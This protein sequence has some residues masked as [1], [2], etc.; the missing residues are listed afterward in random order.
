MNFT[1]VIAIC[2]ATWLGFCGLP[3]YAHAPLVEL[4]DSSREQPIN[5]TWSLD[6]SIAIYGFLANRS[7]VDVVAFELD[8]QKARDGTSLFFHTLVPAC[9]VY[10]DLLPTVAVVGPQQAALPTKSSDDSLPFETGNNDGIRILTNNKQGTTWYEPYSKKNYF[11]QQSA[12]LILNKP[13]RYYLYTWSSKGMT[14]DYVLSIGK[15]E[16]W[17]LREIGR[18]MR[19]MP[20][21]LGDREIHSAACRE[22][23][24]QQP[25]STNPLPEDFH[26]SAQ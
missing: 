8:E 20:R 9:E 15:K 22:E 17:G 5:I 4:K 1:K 7:D 12:T 3:S 24:K 23:L 16:T 25:P 18:A 26:S 13:G 10:R 6:T 21:L 14:G 19:H 11:W 2:T